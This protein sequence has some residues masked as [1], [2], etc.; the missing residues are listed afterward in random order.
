MPDVEIAALSNSV[1]NHSSMIS[2]I[3]IGAIF[4][5]SVNPLVPCFLKGDSMERIDKASFRLIFGSFG[6]VN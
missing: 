2:G 6:G 3:I 5:K 1:S 4:I